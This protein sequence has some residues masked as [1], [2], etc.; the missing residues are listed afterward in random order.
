MN[1]IS[2]R[3]LSLTVLV[4]AFLASM[5][6]Q[7]MAQNCQPPNWPN[8]DPDCGQLVDVVV[9]DDT[10]NGYVEV[11][12]YAACA[13]MFVGKTCEVLVSDRTVAQPGDPIRLFVF[14]LANPTVF[15]TSTTSPSTTGIGFVLYV[16]D[17]DPIVYQGVNIALRK[18][19]CDSKH[20]EEP[21]SEERVPK[22][23][24]G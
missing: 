3:A 7:L 20:P 8:P 5:H 22:N 11:A 16:D 12:I 14:N 2:R 23:G 9:S 21:D 17:C 19:N 13:K 15:G 6:S 1:R 4:S 24:K 10:E 18:F